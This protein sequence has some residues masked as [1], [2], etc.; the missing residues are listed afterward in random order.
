MEP[1]IS[2]RIQK[3]KPSAT[4]AISAAAK[5]MR[6]EGRDVI[7]LGAGEPDFDTPDHIKAAAIKA[8]Q[9]GF[10]KYTA[11]DGIPSLKEA[12]IDKFK[13]DNQLHYNADQVIVANGGKQN[14]Y[15]MMQAV[16]NP[17][18]EVIIPAPYWVSYPDMAVL[19]DAVPVFLRAGLE[20]SFKITPQQLESAITAQTR[21]FIL[22]SPSNPTGASYRREEL[23]ALAKVLDNHPNILIASDDIYEHIQLTDTPFCHIL[24]V[25]PQLA[26]RTIVLN[27]VSKVYSMTGW[28]IG[29]AAGPAHIIKAMKKV[30]SQSTSNPCSI[31][32]VAAEAALRGDQSCL[33]E[34]I[35]AFRQRHLYVVAALNA[36][37]DVSCLPSQGAFY[38]FP[39]FREV[40]KRM[41]DIDNDTELAD[42]L[43]K[44][45]NVALVPGSAFGQSGYLRI[46]FAT[47]MENLEKAM[48]RIAGAIR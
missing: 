11:V 17:K 4:L 1:H 40:I 42:Y 28:R 13:R 31:S 20:Q 41:P 22:N 36:M 15:N 21:M 33:N 45:A 2:N 16:L 48:E 38:S 9:D 25:A 37:P 23:L 19:A 35:A 14:I 12:V 46:S 10:T 43:L 3:V 7:G 34:M 26:D 5:Q 32:Q 39:D 47:G 29:Y 8:I 6:A 24:N 44:V 27:G 30:Q 18:D